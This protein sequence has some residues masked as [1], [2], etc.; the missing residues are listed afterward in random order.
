MPMGCYFQ[1][2]E[3]DISPNEKDAHGICKAFQNSTN[4]V[5]RSAVNNMTSYMISV[6]PIIIIYNIIITKSNS[7]LSLNKNC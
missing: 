2:L 1:K 4:L 3:K 5:A 6:I 7:S